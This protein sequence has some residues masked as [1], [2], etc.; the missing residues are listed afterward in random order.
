MAE[1]IACHFITNIITLFTT[2]MLT[3]AMRRKEFCTRTC[4]ETKKYTLQKPSFVKI[5][6]VRFS[7][8][9]KGRTKNVFVE[10]YQQRIE[11]LLTAY[12]NNKDINKFPS[13]AA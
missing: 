9:F 1:K 2:P 13:S 10:E 6:A 8:I 7:T 3:G 5:I 11:G 4:L 12:Q